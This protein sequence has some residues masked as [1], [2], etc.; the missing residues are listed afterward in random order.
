MGRDAALARL[1]EFAATQGTDP[2]DVAKA[3]ALLLGYDARWANEP[4]EVL[5]VQPTFRMPLYNPKNGRKSTVYELGGK[6][7][8]LV[9]D[10]RTREIVII[11][12][13]TTSDKINPES[14]YW[15]TVSVLD[16]QIS[17]YYSGARAVLKAMGLKEDPARAIYDVIHKPQLRPLKATPFDKREYR[18]RDGK[19]K[20]NQRENDETP[21]EYED[22]LLE[23]IFGQ[24]IGTIPLV[25][26]VEAADEAMQKYFARGDIVRL[27]REEREH[28]EDIWVTSQIIRENEL[29]ERAPRHRGACKRYGGFC[30]FF[31]VCGGMARIEDFILSEEK[32][33]ELKEI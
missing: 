33:S 13:K 8:V 12:T 1:E 19:L 24:P 10:I 7:D 32:H 25:V 15:H 6:L 17:M 18:K 27:E 9:R 23:D 30:P 5:R 31:A 26:D 11:E 22:R 28:A 14:T 29:A 20:A 16:P 4:Y 21:D 3:R 2:F